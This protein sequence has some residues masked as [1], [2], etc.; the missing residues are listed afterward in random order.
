MKKIG[1]L[2]IIL[3]FL[4]SSNNYCSAQNVPDQRRVN[5][6]DDWKFHFGNA[7]D[8]LKDFNYSIAN[9]FSKTGKAEGTAIDQ[10][11]NDTGWRIL[12][13]P[14]D[15]AVE[16]PFADSPNFDVMA[17][18]Y[19]P[20]GG[21]FPETSIGWYR[22]HFRADKKDSGQR[23]QIQFDGVFRDANVWINGIYLGNN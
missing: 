3:S 6:D 2:L 18:G 7:S 9:I 4:I 1:G 12:N 10:K 20:V 15:W 16:L 19:K 22:K 21:L 13:M 17:H 14:H 23:F 8:P 11:F 5:F